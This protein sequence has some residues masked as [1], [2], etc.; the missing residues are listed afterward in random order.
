M[1]SG[2]SLV[3]SNLHKV[4]AARSSAESGL[5]AVRYYLAQAEIPGLT[6]KNE[7]FDVLQSQLLG[8]GILPSGM[9]PDPIIEDG[10]ITGITIGTTLDSNKSF[11][12]QV[13]KSDERINIF[14]T[15]NAHSI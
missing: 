1:S 14:V 12:A 15:G 10:V 7:R 3:A 11:T 2:N 5:E 13:R 4:N 6:P 8:G 9:N